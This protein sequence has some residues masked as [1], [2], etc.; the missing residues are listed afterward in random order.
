MTKDKM[1]E[2]PTAILNPTEEDVKNFIKN[3]D[4]NRKGYLV[5]RWVDE[6]H[7]NEI[8]D[9]EFGV[10]QVIGDEAE[11]PEPEVFINGEPLDMS[12][13]PEPKIFHF[14]E[15]DIDTVE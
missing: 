4:P 8:P 13:W 6:D 14:D 1:K 15:K 11:E 7:F 5:S 3:F 10:Y 12:S 2:T 9:D